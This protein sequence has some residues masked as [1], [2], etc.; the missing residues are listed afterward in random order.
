MTRYRLLFVAAVA[1]GF[2][3]LT[4]G[5]F[6]PEASPFAPAFARLG[7]DRWHAAG[8]RGK[9]RKI[10]ILDTGFR[11]YQDYL[12][13]ILPRSVGARSFRTDGELEGRDSR[14][15]I[16]CGEIAHA[17]APE[18]ELLFV[19]WQPDSPRSFI[20]AIT[21]A[22]RQGA[23]VISCS[24]IMPCWSDGEG[25]G[26]THEAIRQLAGDG[27]HPGDPILVAC[28]G[29]VA[30]RHWSGAYAD[31]GS[32]WHRWSEKSAVNWLTAW[33]DELVS[34]ELCHRPESC[35]LL[36]VLTAEGLLVGQAVN[37]IDDSD[38]AVVVRFPAQPNKKYQVRVRLTYGPPTPFHLTV[39]GG[40]LEH[41]KAAGSIPFPGDGAEWLTVG[42]WENNQRATYSSCGPN[43]AAPKP[44]LV[45]AVPFPSRWRAQPFGGTSAAAPQA[46]A[47]AALYGS[48]Y[49]GLTP[50]DVRAA[51]CTLAADV[52]APG[53]DLETGYGR[54]RLQ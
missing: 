26:P 28:A 52:L 27:K 32:G 37:R 20:D 47:L 1:A 34:V 6:T 2:A 18:A 33:G 41:H 48:R 12:G 51:L 54:L 42:A 8:F 11:G 31:A 39:L 50:A 4:P 46:A 38:R 45:A 30:E 29:N 53:H 14:H 35:Y 40:W 13:R 36:Q 21:W 24:V 5:K 23:H 19:N 7:V 10:A 44:D 16:L 43:S 15:G 9:G 17:I 49:P 22:K 25:G 3:S